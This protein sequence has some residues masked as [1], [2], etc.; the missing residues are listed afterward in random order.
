MKTPRRIL[1]I[2]ATGTIGRAVIG[3]LLDAGVAVRALTRRPA[4]ALLP[5]AVEA[6][7]GDLTAPES[8]EPA[9]RE[10][11]AVFMVWTAPPATVNDVVRQLARYVRRVVFLS[12][13]HQTPHPFFQQPN[14]VA[15]LHANIER[16]LAEARLD[17]TILR[18]GMF[19]ANAEP[20]W[21]SQIR[22]GDVVRW[23]YADAA[24]AP[25]DQRDVAAVG[26]RVLLDD[27]HI[28]AEY[29]L[30]GPESLTHA[31]QVATIASVLGRELRF[32]SLSPDAYR[33]AVAGSVPPRVADMLLA[34]WDAAVGLPAFVTSNV[35]KV[36]G[37][38]PRTFRQWVVDHAEAFGGQRSMNKTVGSIG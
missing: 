17:V 10:V 14:P 31:A 29:V 28:G 1:V 23:P 5:A 21:A 25:V 15:T 37:R 6:V 11:D 35:A 13:P 22:Q 33:S 7:S 36:T 24:S 34:A 12:S 16:A 26:A 2:G 9:L 18:P 38:P 3:Q 8:L 19:A 30:T 32:E 27:R 20:W 4:A